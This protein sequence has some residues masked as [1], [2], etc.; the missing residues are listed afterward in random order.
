MHPYEIVEHTAEIG[1]RAYGK[2]PQELFAHMAQGMF[3]LIVAPEEVQSRERI[4]VAAQA[5]DWERLLVA[6]LRELLFLFDTQHFLSVSF[7]IDR[8]TPT[9]IQATAIGEKLDPARHHVDKEVKAATYC[10]L[11]V[12]QQPGGSWVAQVIFDV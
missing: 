6:W 5:Q 7:E 8:L 12:K 1:I 9:Q 2:N 3:S 10:D 11:S 4:P